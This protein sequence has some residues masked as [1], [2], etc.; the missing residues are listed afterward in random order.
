M[1]DFPELISIKCILEKDYFWVTTQ[2]G[3]RTK[4]SISKFSIQN[5]SLVVLLFIF[6]ISLDFVLGCI[7]HNHYNTCD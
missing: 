4:F 5:I 1:L 7:D 3:K 2:N 6:K